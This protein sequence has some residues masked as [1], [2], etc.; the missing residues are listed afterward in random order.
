MLLHGSSNP[1]ASCVGTP[2][3]PVIAH[4]FTSVVLK[5]S[6]LT[7]K[8]ARRGYHLSREYEVDPLEILFVK[9]VM[10]TNVAVL[11]PNLSR[12]DLPESL[13]SSRTGQRL[14]PVSSADGNLEGVVT[15]EDLQK[16]VRSPSAASLSDVIRKP[17]AVAY[18]DEPLRMVVN[19][20]ADTGLTR[21]PV[22]ESEDSQKLAGIVSLEDLLRARVR[23]QEE[24]RRRERVLRIHLPFASNGQTSEVSGGS[25]EGASNAGE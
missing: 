7:E 10:R 5:R 23:H 21:F 6:I 3:Q 20:M 16:L 12:K 15:R 4:F 24:E 17:R 8:V 14:Y 25:A 1:E 13:H 2:P 18:P 11:T 22:V 9:D 19:R